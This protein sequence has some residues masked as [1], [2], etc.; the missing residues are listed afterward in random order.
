MSQPSRSVTIIRNS[1]WLAAVAWFAAAANPLQAE[2]IAHEGFA[3]TAGEDLAGQNGGLGWSGPWG[4]PGGWPVTIGAPGLNTTD[5]S[6]VT[7]PRTDTTN[8]P[9]AFYG[10]DLATALGTTDSTVY[11]AFELRPDEGYG[12]YGGLNLVGATGGVYAGLS[13]NQTTYGLEGPGEGDLTL[14]S[15]PATVDEIV[16][17]VVR[18]GFQSGADTIDLFVNPG[19]LLSTP[20]A[21][22]SYDLGI[23][24]NI[25]L[26]NA[27]GYTT[28]EIRIGTTY[29]DVMV[30]EP[31]S[32]S[33]AALGLTL[34]AFSARHLRRRNRSTA[35]FA[36]TEA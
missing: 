17:L 20:D 7:A 13:G 29:A 30:P 8:D 18:I 11:F 9:I 12:F 15:V 26:N 1:A 24:D 34:V 28:D 31:S 27:G 5:G 16:F 25:Y 36:K 21:M 4:T 6:A 2:L 33:L 19:A 32:L 22:T 23:L 14:T 10:R 3:Y 35:T